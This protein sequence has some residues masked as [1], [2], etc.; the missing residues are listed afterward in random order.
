MNKIH[1]QNQSPK[2]PLHSK[3]L[4]RS[5]SPQRDS[6]NAPFSFRALFRCSTGLIL[7]GA[8][9]IAAPSAGAAQIL[10]DNGQENIISSTVAASDWIRVQS[11]SG[12]TPTTVTFQD[13]AD[14][15]GNSLGRS[16]LGAHNSVVQINGG[17]FEHDVQIYNSANVTIT[18]GTLNG[19]LLLLESAT[20]HITGGTMGDL[21]VQGSASVTMTAGINEGNIFLSGHS[22]SIAVSGGQFAQN[23]LWELVDTVTLTLTGTAFTLNGAPVGAGPITAT[24][25]TL[26]GTLEDG[27]SFDDINFL[28]RSES[29]GL[30]TIQLNIIPEPSTFA[31]ASLGGLALLRRK[32]R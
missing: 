9:V 22:A 16:V 17:Y 12:G 24:S 21:S 4:N 20:G 27:S 26:S 18:G 5:A 7:F 23:S 31:L 13:G 28:R 14:V 30:G 3:L 10:Y 11:S 25:G 1:P 32:R 6:R 29:F 8:A 2:A 15:R 19:S